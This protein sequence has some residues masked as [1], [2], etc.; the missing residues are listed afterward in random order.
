MKNVFLFYLKRLFSLSK[1][2]IFCN[3][4]PSFP[5]F[6]DS[7]GQME[8]EYFMMPRIGLHTFANVI[9]GIIQKSLYITS[10]NLVR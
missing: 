9:F 1:Y 6:P 7:K 8:V 5:N 3:F 10:S 4:F 2:S